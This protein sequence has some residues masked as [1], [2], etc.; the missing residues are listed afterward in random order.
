MSFYHHYYSEGFGHY[1]AYVKIKG[2]WYLFDDCE[3][4]D[5]AT[6]SIPPLIQ[7][8]Q[9]KYYPMCFYYVKKK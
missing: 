1:V 7:N 9:E 6:K 8:F 3:N 2:E 4:Y 5:Y